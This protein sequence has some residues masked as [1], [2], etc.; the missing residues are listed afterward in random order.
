MN[1]IVLVVLTVLF[2]AL[3]VGHAQAAAA[4]D[5][6]AGLAAV[7][8]DKLNG[9][10][11]ASGHIYN[12]SKLTAAHKTLPFGT[13]VKVTNERNQR[14]VV[15]LINDRGPVQQDRILDISPAAAKQLHMSRFTMR[16]VSME[17]IALGSGRR[18]HHHDRHHHRGHRHH[19]H[20][21]A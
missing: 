8:S 12:R 20:K 6:E 15:L 21:H 13:K 4:G 10:I 1:R 17:V 11:T 7:Y 16:K 19:H 2:P 14:S 3:F 9:H 5:K 18:S